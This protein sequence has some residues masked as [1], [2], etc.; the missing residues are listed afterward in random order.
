M[1]VIKQVPLQHQIAEVKRELAQR[2]TVYA[3]LIRENKMPAEQAEDRMVRMQA[4][5]ATLEEL[6]ALE[7]MREPPSQ[8]SD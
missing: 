8:S 4:V 1:N 3:R 2:K 6:R 5:L 7:L